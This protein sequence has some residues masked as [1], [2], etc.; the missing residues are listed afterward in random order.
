MKSLHL[1]PTVILP[2]DAATQTFLIVGKRGSGKSNTGTCVAEELH[3]A[4]IPFAVL[5]PVDVWWG[6][7]AGKGGHSKGG[8]DVYVFG[9]EH[10]DIPL[11]PTAGVMMADVLVEHR[12]SAV[13]VLRQFSNREKAK[14]VADFAEQLFKRNRD[15]L[16]LFCEEAHEVM[17]QQPYRGEEE[18]LGRMLKLQKLGRTSGI[19][20]TA[21]TQ[22]P[23]S[24]NK[25]ATTQAEILI[26][27]RLLGPQ[28]RDAVEAW[29]KHHHQ[30]HLKQEVLATLPELKTG[31]AWLWAPDFPEERPLGLQRV[32]IREAETFD[33]RR[34]PKPGEHR[35][36][37]KT[38][39]PVDLDRLKTKMAATIERA[40]AEDPR[41][42]RRRVAELERELQ[43]AKRV[44]VPKTQSAPTI[45]K[46][47]I[48]TDAQ[49]KRLE[50]LFAKIVAESERHGKAMAMFWKNQDEVAQALIG[51]IR[52]FANLPVPRPPTDLKL[53]P[54]KVVFKPAPKDNGSA[55]IGRSAQRILNALV[56]AESIGLDEVDKTQLALM[57]DQRPTSG[58]YFNNLGKLRSAGLIT[59]PKAG[60][61][62]LTDAG[63]ACAEAVDVPTT[64]D[65]L[66]HMLYAK[67]P[68]SQ[69]RI[70]KVLIAQYPKAIT[71][72]DL[73]EQTQQSPTSGGYFNNLGR[74]RSLGLIDYPSPGLAVAQPVLFLQTR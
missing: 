67:L 44:I 41:E 47:S 52:S 8:L 58:G 62:R 38:F 16:H 3:E 35:H 46:K 51:A 31:E 71:K 56:W 13:F 1:S 30:E 5:D 22:R 53:V 33:S 40:K 66:Q 24:L 17:P 50:T 69:A 4:K 29:I 32:K 55:E 10:A 64:S 15:V 26:A 65:E 19:G 34:T 60:A 42:L 27:H 72:D 25:N 18:M 21:I 14:F 23:A 28:D 49:I 6:L 11:E 74:L 57:S 9:G 73:A 43:V 68:T 59:Y 36:E 70:L 2:A 20:L 61:A 45:D 7:K 54:G 48:I 63:R 37:P 12:I 39:T